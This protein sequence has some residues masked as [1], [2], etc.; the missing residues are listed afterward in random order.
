MKQKLVGEISFAKSEYHQ[1]GR[2]AS[3]KEALCGAVHEG[4]GEGGGACSELK[5]GHQHVAVGN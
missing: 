2:R 1:R 5:E 3:D 4:F